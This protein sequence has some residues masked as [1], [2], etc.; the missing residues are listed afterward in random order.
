MEDGRILDKMFFPESAGGRG[1]VMLVIDN[2]VARVFFIHT[3]NCTLFS[4]L[5]LLETIKFT[6]ES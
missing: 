4:L 1:T 2:I 6:D 5:D 3:C